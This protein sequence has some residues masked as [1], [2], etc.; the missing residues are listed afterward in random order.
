MTLGRPA[1]IP[2]SFVRLDLPTND[3]DGDG[4]TETPIVDSKTF[5]MS[6]EFFNST[7]YVH[8]SE[9]S[10]PPPRNELNIS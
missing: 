4:P 5:Q 3:I 8:I 1:A 7:M 6:V 10:S 2:D 9:V